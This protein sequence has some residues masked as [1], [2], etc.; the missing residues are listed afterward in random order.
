MKP[1]SLPDPADPLPPRPLDPE[2]LPSDPEPLPSEPVVGM[3]RPPFR[4][5]FLAHGDDISSKKIKS[6]TTENQKKVIG[7]I[8]QN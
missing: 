5:G 1:S 8:I 2:P 7:M 4:H 6:K 3:H